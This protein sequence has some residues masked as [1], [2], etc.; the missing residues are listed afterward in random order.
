MR[1]TRPYRSSLSFSHC[2]L[3]V[4]TKRERERETHAHTGRARGHAPRV[5]VWDGEGGGELANAS[6]CAVARGAKRTDDESVLNLDLV[7]GF[8]HCLNRAACAARST[9]RSTLRDE[10][11]GWGGGRLATDRLLQFH[12][13]AICRTHP[14]LVRCGSVFDVAT[15]L[16]QRVVPVRQ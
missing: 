10:V 14:V 2:I 9:V 11:S 13:S 6:E 5:P 16:D 1:K 8:A 12:Q 15:K 4:Y 3:S 7:M